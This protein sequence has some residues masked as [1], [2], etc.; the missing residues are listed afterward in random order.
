MRSAHGLVSD[1][2]KVV[3][4]DNSLN[5]F[6]LF[7]AFHRGAGAHDDVAVEI[8]LKATVQ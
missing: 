8:V 1:G 7:K 4:L 3:L 5:T 6:R 2:W